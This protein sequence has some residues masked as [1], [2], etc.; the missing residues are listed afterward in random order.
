MENEIAILVCTK[1][2]L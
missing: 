2:S 1:R